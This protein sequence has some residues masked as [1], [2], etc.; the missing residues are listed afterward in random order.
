MMNHGVECVGLPS[1]E[2]WQRRVLDRA[3]QHG[4]FLGMQSDE[5][6]FD[7]EHFARYHDAF[8]TEIPSRYPMP[9]YLTLDALDEFY[10]RHGDRYEVTFTDQPAPAHD[11]WRAGVTLPQL[12]DLAVAV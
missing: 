4:S 9:G 2:D 6:P 5:F 11:D 3:R 8:Q 12:R 10:E 1:T 7:L